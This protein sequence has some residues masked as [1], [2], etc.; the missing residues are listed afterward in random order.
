MGTLKIG[1]GV[2]LPFGTG[3]GNIVWGT[4]TDFS[5]AYPAIL[6]MNGNDTQRQRPHRRPGDLFEDD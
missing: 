2:A 1:T 3:K 4:Q 6:D 5:S